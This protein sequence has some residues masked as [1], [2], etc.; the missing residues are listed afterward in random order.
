[1]HVFYIKSGIEE[2]QCHFR[3]EEDSSVQLFILMII[4]NDRSKFVDIPKKYR[5]QDRRIH[6]HEKSNKRIY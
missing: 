3:W 2:I 6:G 5:Q 4:E 1:M